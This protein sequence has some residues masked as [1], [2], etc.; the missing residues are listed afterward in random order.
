MERLEA[1]LR[2]LGLGEWQK[3]PPRAPPPREVAGL[4]QL[5][6]SLN[7]L[8]TVSFGAA[9]T[10]A[11]P[12]PPPLGAPPPLPSWQLGQPAPAPPAQ[13]RVPT[14]AEMLAAAPPPRHE[15]RRAGAGD[16]LEQRLL[17]LQRW[18]PVTLAA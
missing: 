18:R 15:S 4:D 8:R 5:Q 7:A 12:P 13:P 17:R 10:H 16:D 2:E 11:P 6:L 3:P 9:R 14:A 1:S